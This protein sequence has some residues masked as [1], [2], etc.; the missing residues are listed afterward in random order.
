MAKSA[1]RGI[2]IKQIRT[3]EDLYTHSY[4]TRVVPPAPAAVVK[5][6]PKVEPKPVEFKTAESVKVSDEMKPTAD[7]LVQIDEPDTLQS[8]QERVVVLEQALTQDSPVIVQEPVQIAESA[9]Q[10]KK[11][12]PKPQKKK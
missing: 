8:M 5:A 4:G 6:V 10:Q 7:T 3:V 2:D 12:T 9:Q 1:F 11:P